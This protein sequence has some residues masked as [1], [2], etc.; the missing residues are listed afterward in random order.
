MMMRLVAHTILF[1]CIIF[2]LENSGE[3]CVS[4]SSRRNRE[5]ESPP[6]THPFATVGSPKHL[7]WRHKHH[8]SE[9]QHLQTPAYRTQIC[10]S[11]C[12]PKI[13]GFVCL[14]KDRL[15]TKDML[16]R[17][18]TPSGVFNCVLCNSDAHEDREHLF[19]LCNF[20]LG[21]WAKIGIHFHPPMEPMESLVDQVKNTIRKPFAFEVFSVSA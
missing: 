6:P 21:C 1:G 18:Y 9:F 2:F 10:K 7:D 20:S 19:G 17:H 3:C 4:F 12:T 5:K 15:N 13:K 14:L 16:E 11:K 8:R